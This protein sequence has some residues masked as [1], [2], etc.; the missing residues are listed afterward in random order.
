MAIMATGRSR[1]GPVLKSVI[2]I[3]PLSLFIMPYEWKT[4]TAL[5]A[6]VEGLN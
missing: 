5:A 4:V 1:I 6:P 2:L 3:T